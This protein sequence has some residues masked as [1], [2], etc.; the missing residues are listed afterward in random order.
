VVV[1]IDGTVYFPDLRD[2][3]LRLRANPF[4]S[5]KQ[6]L[7][8][9]TTMTGMMKYLSGYQ[10]SKQHPNQNYAREL[11]ELFTLGRVHPQTGATNYAE[12]DVQEIARALTG[13]QYN[14]TTG[15]SFYQAGYHDTGSKTFLGAARGNA[16]VP[17]VIAAVSSHPSWTY[18]VPKRMYRELV[19][20]DPDA[21]TL[22]ELAPVFGPTGDLNAL[23][24]AIAN[25][26]E[27]LSDAAIG[28]RIKSPVELVAAAAKALGVHD[29]SP[30]QLSWQMRDMMGQQAFLPPNVSGWPSGPRWL[31]AGYL[32]T[33][34]SL[35][36]AL[37]AS[38][39]NLAGSPVQQLLTGANKTTAAAVGGG[40]V[41]L[42][43]LQPST[44]A[45]VTTYAGGGSWDVNR[46]AGVI[47]L[48]LLSPDFL[49]N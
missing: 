19:G 7:A 6:L 14:W 42:P 15:A 35:A 38:V 36:N 44:A 39:R 45:A 1:G 47:T 11:M 24:A 34:C 29:L 31:H 13:W 3:I 12:T 48:L 25:R 33:W 43:S 37:V 23:V 16:G 46:A 30:F 4:G 17:E 21:A 2:H 26:P 22:D 20:F 10:N 28:A 40:L 27:F 9:V 5:Y 18:H 8:D 49:A 32:M 41:G